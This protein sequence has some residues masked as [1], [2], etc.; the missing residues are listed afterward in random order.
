MNIEINKLYTFEL[1][2][3]F[4]SLSQEKVNK[5]FCDGRRASGFLELQ[6]EEW[7]P[8]LSFVDQKGYDHIDNN[9]VKYDAK[10]FTKG[11]A[12]FCPSVMLGAGRKIDE[13]MLWEHAMDMIYIFCDVVDFPKV[14][15]M[16]KRG[17]DLTHYRKG[18]IPFG[19]RNAI[20]A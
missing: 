20:F 6:L 15:V 18:S 19:D 9:G 11:G 4:G 1:N 14:S 3:S 12:K 13:D 7:F 5:L 2:S 8:D 10:C 16:F 17:S